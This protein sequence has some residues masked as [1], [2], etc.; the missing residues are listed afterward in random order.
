M[1]KK[2]GYVEIDL[3]HIFQILLQR[4]WILVASAVG[5]ALIA[6]IIATVFVT[7]KYESK[8]MLY[9]NNSSFNVGNASFSISSSDL[10]AAQSLVDTY[11][12]ILNTRTTL[13]EVIEETGIDKDY[14]EL[15]NMISASAENN[16]EIFGVTVTSDDPAEAK[17]IANTIAKVLP[18]KVESIVDGASMRIVDYAVTPTTKSSPSV[19]KYTAIGMLLGLVI[20]AAAIIVDDMLDDT[21][22]D[23]EY[24]RT[25]YPNIPLLASIPDLLDGEEETPKFKKKK[26]GKK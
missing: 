14:T 15:K 17:L 19:M 9:V 4:I 11:I 21:I 1:E 23:I 20:S 25:T 8:V 2:Q 24:I 26:G 6:F 12:V 7:P 5:G 18:D 16:T 13:N 22:H 10:T 3:F